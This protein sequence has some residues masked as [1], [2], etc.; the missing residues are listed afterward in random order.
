MVVVPTSAHHAPGCGALNQAPDVSLHASFS[1]A[2]AAL[3]AT[4][5]TAPLFQI[6]L[7]LSG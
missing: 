6:R 7:F 2:R 5:S 4:W 1:H 3:H